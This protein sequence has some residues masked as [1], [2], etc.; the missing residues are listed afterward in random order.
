MHSFPRPPERQLFAER[1]S[2]PG[3]CP[4][5]G[6]SELASYRVL[7]EGGW[8]DVRKCQA[9]LHSVSREPA[10]PLGSYTPLGLEI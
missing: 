4:E 5:C 8:R 7:G 9:C 10:P 6:A 2:V 3:T 1:E